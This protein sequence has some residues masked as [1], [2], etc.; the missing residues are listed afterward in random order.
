MVQQSRSVCSWYGIRLSPVR[1]VIGRVR[2]LAEIASGAYQP[3]S[4]V[5][6][7][8]ALGAAM[9]KLAPATE[10]ASSAT[11]VMPIVATIEALLTISPLAPS[12]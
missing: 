10:A 3:V 1:A 5:G 11:T 12:R 6:F 2:P 4:F 8:S 7:I 9:F